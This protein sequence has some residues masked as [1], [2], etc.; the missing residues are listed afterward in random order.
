[1]G[2]ESPTEASVL[3]T[4]LGP[5]S[6]GWLLPALPPPAPAVIPA[7][8]AIPA[9]PPVPVADPYDT[10]SP[11]HDWGPVLL[12]A[13]TVAKQF[14]LASP[15]ADLQTTTGP[16]FNAVPFNPN[17]VARTTVGTGTFTF[18]DANNGTFSYTVNGATQSK[19][20]ARYVYASPTTVCQ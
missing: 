3:E 13:T 11:Y 16:A 1:M 17:N 18:T 10:S 19:P 8:P 5:P 14:K 12:D 9:P 7:P 6:F 20:I 2:G 4:S 15:I